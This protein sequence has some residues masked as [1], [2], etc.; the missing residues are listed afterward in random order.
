MVEDPETVELH[1]GVSP[2]SRRAVWIWRWQ[3]RERVSVATLCLPVK[4]SISY[5]EP[6]DLRLYS[7]GVCGRLVPL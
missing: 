4:V 5:T 3:G 7:V 6:K 2:L 1:S